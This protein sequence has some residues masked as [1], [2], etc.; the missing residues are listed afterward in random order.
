[1]FVEPCRTKELILGKAVEWI[2]K[3][4]AKK[5]GM[6]MLFMDSKF[7]QP[8]NVLCIHILVFEV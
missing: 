1:V 5:S 6:E 8:Q 3:N 7:F 4:L 2:S